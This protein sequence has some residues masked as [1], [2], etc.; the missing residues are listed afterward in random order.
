MIAMVIMLL[1]YCSALTNVQH[2]GV[3]LKT[4]MVYMPG[5]NDKLFG[6]DI[7]GNLQERVHTGGSWHWVNHGNDGEK[8]ASTPCILKD[9]KIFIISE[10]GNLFERHWWAGSWGSTNHKSHSPLVK[11]RASGCTCTN[12]NGLG[13]VFVVGVDLELYERFWNNNLQPS[14]W[15][16]K[17]HHTPNSNIKVC[18]VILKVSME[19]PSAH[20]RRFYCNQINCV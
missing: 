16:W 13:R 11:I 4:G 10:K 9:G 20:V 18:I 6:V 19:S 5:N 7:H 12:T 8:L 14:G 15:D 2:P 1:G 17:P 3:Q